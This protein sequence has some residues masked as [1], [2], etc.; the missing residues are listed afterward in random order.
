VLSGPVI[1]GA[2]VGMIVTLALIVLSQ[3]NP[4]VWV[5]VTLPAPAAPHST[6]ML[7][8]VLEPWIVPLVTDQLYVLPAMV[9]I[10]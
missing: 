1:T 5:T 8:F 4:L 7:L 9:L 10:L 3:P 6:L 2:G